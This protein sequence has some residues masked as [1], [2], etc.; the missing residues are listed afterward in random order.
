MGTPANAL[1]ITQVGLVQFDGINQF[2]GLAA[3]SSGNVA[4]SD[5][6]VWTSAAPS[7]GTWGG[8]TVTT[9]T[10]T[11]SSA[12]I[13]AIHGTP[14]QVVAAQGSGKV[15]VPVSGTFKFI[16]GGTNVFVAGASQTI[17]LT[18]GTTASIVV[19]T[20]AILVGTT[21]VLYPTLGTSSIQAYTRFDNAALNLYNS[22]A[23]EITGNAAN[24]NTLAYAL[25]YIVVTI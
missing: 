19:Y 3:G 9:V 1:D 17:T 24:N 23:T 18:W 7:G 11:V 5:G 22:V 20:N 8:Y 14:I 16:Y 4:T 15:I 10:G 13:K 2:T 21:T 25:S 6:S 12:Q